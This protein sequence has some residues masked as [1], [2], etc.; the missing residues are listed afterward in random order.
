MDFQSVADSIQAMTC[1]V[2]VE[3]LE[4]GG[5]GTIR[6]V[7]GNKAYID[8]IEHPP[9]EVEMLT[10]EFVPN[11][12]Y[13][14][15]LPKDLNFEDFCYRSAVEKKCLHSYAH[16]DRFDVWFNMI[17]MPL[18]PDDGNISYCTYT[19]EIHSE[20]DSAYVSD[21]SGDIAA[22]V[23]K[24]TLI[25]KDTTNI[26]K[27]MASVVKSIRE[28]CNA[29]RCCAVHLDHVQRKCTILGVDVVEHA[30][31]KLIEDY[32]ADSFYEVAAT[33]ESTISGSN[34]LIIKNDDEM[35]VLKERNPEWY[36]SLQDFNVKTLALFPL[37]SRDEL[38]GYMWVTG[39][40]PSDA[41]KIKEAL[42][43][44]T[45]I[46]SSEIANY[47]LLEK[48]RVLSANDMLTGVRNRNEMN[49]VVDLYA[50]GETIATEPLGVIFA[51][52][53]GLKLIN[54]QD[55]HDAGDALLKRAALALCEV[56][57]REYIYR[58]GGDEFSI[59]VPGLDE[60]SVE[61]KIEQLREVSKKYEAVSLAL[62][63]SI[64][65]KQTD[66]HQ[67]LRNADK[68]MYIDKR[69]YYERHPEKESRSLRDDYHLPKE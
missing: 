15:Y 48:L 61:Q 53:N 24:T 52:L 4:G 64:A 60:A 31:A 42:E 68:K 59:I 12:E 54:D 16:P 40:D 18:G 23:L 34:C 47:Y 13:T 44:T 51:D 65:P 3:K 26:K 55:G 30:E 41:P 69:K 33:W 58:A 63:G 43:S 36:A 1:I 6:I 11:S 14:R 2:S 66:I 32:F 57:D 20:P 10:R 5:H 46:L 19:M 56:F 38:F 39:F 22:S 8:S 67:A 62:G 37:K 17:F 45:F 49:N 21:V 7:T 9:G 27:N 50:K 28:L 35:A 29:Q 25:F